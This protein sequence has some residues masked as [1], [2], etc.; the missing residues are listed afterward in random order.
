MAEVVH[1]HA[2]CRYV[3]KFEAGRNQCTQIRLQVKKAALVDDGVGF[4]DCFCGLRYAIAPIQF[5]KEHVGKIVLGPYLPTGLEK[6]PQ[7]AASVDPNIQLKELSDQIKDMRPVPEKA[8]T[9][10][11]SAL[12]TVIDVILFSSHKAHVTSHM[13]LA[14]IRESYRELTKKNKELQEMHDE[15]KEFE[16][17]K[18]NF[19]ATISHEL[20]TPLT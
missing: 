9:R 16:R 3:N 5:Q 10:I 19:L 14:S 13:H 1:P 20:R 12:L 8:I 15:M 18:S 17:V 11:T 6:A 2:P 7:E 4:S